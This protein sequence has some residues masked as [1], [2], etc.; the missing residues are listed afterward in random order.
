MFDKFSF[1]NFKYYLL[2]TI[3]NLFKIYSQYFAIVW[4]FLVYL[5]NGWNCTRKKHNKNKND[6]NLS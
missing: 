3:I 1:K 5:I 6:K 4:Y 2:F